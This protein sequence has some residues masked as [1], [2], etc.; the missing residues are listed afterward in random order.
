MNNADLLKYEKARGTAYKN[1]AAC[2]HPPGIG[3]HETLMELERQAEILG[4]EVSPHVEV[5]RSGFAG[6][7]D[8]IDDLC[9]DFARLFIGP[10]ALL[11]PPY[12]SVYLDGERRVMGNSTMHVRSFYSDAGLELS[13][14][15]KEPPDHILPRSSSSCISWFSRKLRQR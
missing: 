5:M 6:R 10:Y 1:I 4:S 14:Q 12:G 15:F 11:A 13:A 9:V 3:L 2:Y 8:D 7:A